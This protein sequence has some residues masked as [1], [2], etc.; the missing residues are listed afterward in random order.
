MGNRKHVTQKKFKREAKQYHIIFPEDH[1]NA[2]LEVLMRSL[3]I[4]EFL[5]LTDLAGGAKLDTTV[6]RKLFTMFAGSLLEWNLQ[7]DFDNDVPATYEGV[8]GQDLD[9]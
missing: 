4:E 5:E 2:G 6:V 1:D 9:F 8:Q 7:D 3:P